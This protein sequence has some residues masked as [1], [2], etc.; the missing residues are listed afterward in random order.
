MTQD[1]ETKKELVTAR[2]KNSRQRKAAIALLRSRAQQ[3][4]GDGKFPNKYFVSVSNEYEVYDKR[5]N[6]VVYK[7]CG[8]I[9]FDVVS[10]YDD[11][12]TAIEDAEAK[13]GKVVGIK[14]LFPALMVRVEDRLSGEVFR[15]S[16]SGLPQRDTKFSEEK[17]YEHRKRTK[18][19]DFVDSIMRYE[20]GQMSESEADCFLKNNANTLRRLQGFY[21]RELARRGY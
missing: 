13:L 19:I 21:G 2:F 8:R 10:E 7:P 14:K 4:V 11:V 3:M 18:G 1:H 17:E 12:N 6:V 9:Q 5:K 20:S 15:H 16:I